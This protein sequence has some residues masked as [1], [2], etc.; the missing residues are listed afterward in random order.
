[1]KTLLL[2][3]ALLIPSMPAVAQDGPINP[4]EFTCAQLLAPADENERTGANMMV[5][6][7]V[8][9][10]YGRFG[11]GPDSAVTPEG[12]EGAVADL[13]NALKQVCPNVPD[14]TIATFAENLANDFAATLEAQE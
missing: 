6:W 8:G 11:G 9:Y 12:Y 14:M 13:V 3:T 4:F 5:M 2:A 7:A 1:M 10:F